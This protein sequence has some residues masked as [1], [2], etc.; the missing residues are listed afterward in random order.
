MGVIGIALCSEPGTLTPPVD[1]DGGVGCVVGGTGVGVGLDWLVVVPPSLGGACT[2]TD[3]TFTGCDW[4]GDTSI[5][6]GISCGGVFSPPLGGEPTC[7][8]V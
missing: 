4:F 2:V 7:V 5:G 6:V 8:P 1:V 3:T